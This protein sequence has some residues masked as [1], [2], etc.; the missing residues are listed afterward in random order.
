MGLQPVQSQNLQFAHLFVMK[1][2]QNQH[3]WLEIKS[4]ITPSFT[5]VIYY[6]S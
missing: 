6:V 5:S 4:A 3:K 2:D 1:L